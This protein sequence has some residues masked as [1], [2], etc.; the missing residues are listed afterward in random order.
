M[1]NSVIAIRAYELTY[2]SNEEKLKPVKD[3]G[4]LTEPPNPTKVRLKKTATPRS[5]R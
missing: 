2:M 4:S 5:A 3:F 1:E